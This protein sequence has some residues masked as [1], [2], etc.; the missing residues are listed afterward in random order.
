MLAI[1]INSAVIGHDVN[2]VEVWRLK[3]NTQIFKTEYNASNPVRIRKI[4]FS[5][6]CKLI[7]ISGKLFNGNGFYDIWDINNFP[8]SQTEFSK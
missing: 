3:D 1:G 7:H 6:N 2:E 5:D 4:M 8:V